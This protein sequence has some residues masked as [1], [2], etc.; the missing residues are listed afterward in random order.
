MAMGDPHGG[1]QRPAPLRVGV[2]GPVRAWLA[3]RELTPGP[4]RQQAVLGVLAMRA[5]RVV[6][7]DELVDAVWGQDAPASA[8][9]GVHTYVAGLRRVL[10][11]GRSR[12]GP[13]QVLAS[14]GAGYVLHLDAGHVDAMVFER[15]LDTGRRLRASG[16][17]SG[18]VS[19]LDAALGEW[20]GSAFAGV[21]G[22]FASSERARLGELRSAAAEERAEL[23]LD[24]G[25]HE[26]AV[27]ELAALVAEHPLR[28]R[29]R[30]L[31]MIALY[32]CGRQAE[33]L[34][35]FHEARQ[36]LGEE[37]GIDPGPELSRIHQQ[38]LALDP[39]L[40]GPGRAAAR[41]ATVQPAAGQ[42]A[43]VSE[44]PAP[45]AYPASP[46]YPAPAQLPLEAPGFSG[47][48][49][50]LDRMHRVIAPFDSAGAGRDG[51][52][53]RDGSPATVQIIA[54][55]GTAGVGK[56]ALAIRFARQV[57]SRYPAG[58][59]YVNLRGFDPSGSAMSPDD[60]LRYFLD[61]FAVPPERIPADLE[62]RAALYRSMLDGQRVLVVLDNARD[63]DQV[64]PLLPGSPG[65][66]VVVTTRSQL[67]SLVAVEGAVPLSLDV[68]TDGEAHDVL[69]RRLGQEVV[70]AEP[71]AAAELIASCARLPLA[72]TITVGRAAIRPAL[73]LAALAAE[74][75]DARNRLDALDAG[76]A[77]TDLRAVLSWSYQQLSP[78]AARMFRLLGMHPGPDISHAVAVSLGG[79]SDD[80][81]G[82][83]LGELTR[84]HMVAEHAPGRFT[85]HD[86][87]RAYAAERA[88]QSGDDAE[89][90]RALGRAVDHYLHTARA[91]AAQV[92]PQRQLPVPPAPQADVAPEEIR[93][94]EQALRW[95]EAE[96][97]VLLA[98]SGYAA[99][100]GV[101]PHG[102]MLPCMLADYLDNLGRWQDF[103]D[104]QRSALAVARR[105]GDTDGEARA[106][107]ELAIACIRQGKL[108]AAEPHLECSLGLYREI[109]DRASEARVHSTYAYKLERE[110]RYG[111][112]LD[113]TQEALR[114]HREV[115][116]RTGEAHA[117]NG[118][119]W[120]LTMAGH[121]RQALSYCREAL[122]LQREL[123]DPRGESA[124]S[125]S[126][127][128]AYY[129]LGDY[130]KALA[131]YRNAVDRAVQA[132]SR[133]TEAISLASLA[134][135]YY[136]T[137]EVAAA[138]DAWLRALA[139][140]DQLRHPDAEQVRAKLHDLDA[141]QGPPADTPSPGDMQWPLGPPRTPVPPE[142]APGD[143]LA[144]G[145]PH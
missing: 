87:L 141:A 5:N 46:A 2:L 104:S 91:A 11:P 78:P 49:A 54:I 3:G 83:A 42:P 70:A 96:H 114:L 71:Q 143:G 142:G 39:G 28:E 122:A 33:A 137:G 10:E 108:E 25:R 135:T 80:D 61:A 92:N 52:D 43:T 119:G 132:G 56:T 50:E 144:A 55:A 107:I 64:R 68:L 34:Q 44:G 124:T 129:Q 14:A 37:L 32:R 58:Q 59:L 138:R 102:W 30:G 65:S 47:R 90:E 139:T 69:S 121:H 109:G 127:G 27:P 125:H 94:Q 136:M 123:G 131:S 60:A 118:I 72:L 62:A 140:F 120:Y 126:L 101:M 40:E 113:H 145:A 111:D 95:F 76:D 88:R 100:A 12:R 99:E 75:R 115:G 51:A 110:E 7:R 31:L 93:N 116:N 15:G 105:F 85:F 128:H 106:C 36:V 57:A 98:V 26:Q 97:S 41:P 74:L 17:L 134:D 53:G 19:A 20:H 117:L 66:L 77:A 4:P 48:H 29:M 103:E 6:S 18:A 21:P 8:E 13:G 82:A 112:A 130:P 24:L 89:R 35:T 9:G 45:L 79:V 84:A 67:T 81:A 23:L 1:S 86:L 38:I 22:P 73:S 16:E 133:Y 63:A